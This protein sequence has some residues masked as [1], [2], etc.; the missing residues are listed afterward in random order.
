[1]I[2]ELRRDE[3]HDRPVFDEH[4]VEQQQRFKQHLQ[5]GR[6][7]L[8]ELEVLVD[9]RIGSRREHVLQLQPLGRKRIQEAFDLGV[10]EHPFDRPVQ[11]VGLG[12]FTALGQSQQLLIGTTSPE[13]QRQVRCQFERRVSDIRRAGSIQKQRRGQHGRSHL[14]HAVRERQPLRHLRSRVGRVAIE[15]LGFDPAAKGDRQKRLQPAFHFGLRVDLVGRLPKEVIPDPDS[16]LV[17][18]RAFDDR[19][20]ESQE[21]IQQQRRQRQLIRLIVESVLGSQIFR[22]GFDIAQTGRGIQ[23]QRRHAHLVRHFSGC[24]RQVVILP[25]HQLFWQLED[26]ELQL[27]QIAHRVVVLK[28][29]QPADLRRLSLLAGRRVAQHRLQRGQQPRAS[30]LIQLRLVFRR[31][32]VGINGVDHLVDERRLGEKL[33][34]HRDRLE[35][36]LAVDLLA[37]VA[38]EAML[39]HQR[40][41]EFGDIIGSTFG[42]DDGQRQHEQ[43]E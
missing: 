18:I 7:V 43:H 35:I 42:P 40:I 19:H 26:V 34:R 12:E 6:V 28:P 25:G 14:L 38:F 33:S 5:A 2:A 3:I 9:L 27:E 17:E 41:Q 13:K 32:V 16:L 10:G 24:G 29:I 39:R 23:S 4:G 11:H 21:R 30:L 15:R 36:D 8:I 22:K 1:M 20:A 31:H 37:A